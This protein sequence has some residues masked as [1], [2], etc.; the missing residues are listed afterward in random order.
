MTDLLIRIENA[1]QWVQRSLAIAILVVIVL[2]S[3]AAVSSVASV[4]LGINADIQDRRA[5]IGRLHAIVKRAEAIVPGASQVGDPAPYLAGD[6]SSL[7]QASLQ[8]SVTEI[9]GRSGATIASMSGLPLRFIDGLPLVG[10][11]IQ[12]DATLPSMENLVSALE[13]AAPGLVIEDAQFR[14]TN[15]NAQDK[16]T[17]PIQLSAQLSIAG[18][19]NPLKIQADEKAK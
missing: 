17:A 6:N 2:L 13:S 3:A 1:P 5:E 10:V 12:V 7:V 19:A 4:L 16:L 18:A 15:A 9:A 8:Q 14:R 11:R